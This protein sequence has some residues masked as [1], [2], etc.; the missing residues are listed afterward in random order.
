M[1]KYREVLQRALEGFFDHA[2]DEEKASAVDEMIRISS[3]RAA[4]L[5]LQPIPVLDGALLTPIQQ[6]MVEAIGAIRGVHD[7]AAVHTLFRT[8]FRRLVGPHFTIAGVKLIP[9][10]PI[11][12]DLIAMSVAYALT[13]AIGRVG[14]LVLQRPSVTEGE[15]RAH[16]DKLYRR[17][18]EATYRE[19]R[20]ELKARLRRDPEVR[21]QLADLKAA[22]RRGTIREEDAERKAEE[23]VKGGPAHP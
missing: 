6:K 1:L 8:L 11:V 17:T 4:M 10:V 3:S 16:F 21:R 5:V 2:S 7:K 23:I 22:R 13:F 20:D 18:F 12:P 19:K 15:V 14:D 9:F